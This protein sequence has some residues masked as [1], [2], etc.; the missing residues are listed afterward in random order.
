MRTFG[1]LKYKM[2]YWVLKGVEPHVMIKLKAIFTKIP[3][4]ATPPLYLKHSPEAA[5]D[6]AWFI[7]RYPLAVSDH[8]RSFL[9]GIKEQH[10]SKMASLEQLFKPDYTPTVFELKKPPRH[11]Q[12]QF[13]DLHAKVQT[14]LLG[15]DVGL[16][17]TISAILTFMN[18]KTLPAAVVVQSHLPMQWKEKV[19]EFSDLKTHTV[20][21]GPVYQ[22]PPADVYIFKY[23]QLAKWVDVLTSGVIKSV[24]FDEIQEFRH[25]GT[26][27]YYAGYAVARACEYVTGM[28][29]TPIYNKGDEIW[30]VMDLI[31]PGCLDTRD[32]FMR[33]WCS[34]W[35]G[36][37]TNPKALGAYLRENFLFL[38]RTREE[39]KME[40]P[41]V[42]TIVER[43]EYEQEEIDRI[44]DLA[45]TLAQKTLHGE[46][47][48][49]GMAARELD[50]LVRHATGV[51]KAKAVAQ[52]VRVLVEAG[53][54]VLLAGWHR[55]VYEIWNKEF[56][57]LN[58]VMYTGSE[59][60]TQKEEAKRKFMSGESPL[61]MIS[62]RS[63]IGL[64]GLQHKASIV[65]IGE[66]DWSPMV[67]EQ[68][69]GRLNRDGQQQQV[70]VVFLVSD[71]GSDP[72]IVELLGLKS[73]QAKGILDPF[74]GAEVRVADTSRIKMLA[75]RY[76]ARKGSDLCQT[77]STSS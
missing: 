61:M 63:G 59:S 53:E 44:E 4:T 26:Q 28:S 27:K 39:V 45:R 71:S 62:L 9:L 19:S 68:I 23:T 55:D 36:T 3:K 74:A 73:S 41:A 57:G 48:E 21:G 15:D 47:T 25:T 24:V 54:S 13:A 49:R 70:T 5:V 58:P 52:Y 76:L 12:A 75:E 6:L 14:L 30:N 17:K 29:A 34:G 72:S 69:I 18:T 56:E 1:T 67:H 43:V 77:P 16:G 2:G 40:L 10:L 51:S 42:N 7:D 32:N 31:K 11:Y 65:V 20:R 33:E 38:R 35:G 50:M 60:P 46:F 66:L 8:D 22:L 37:V 64:D